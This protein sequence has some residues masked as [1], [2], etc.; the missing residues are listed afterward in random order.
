MS[1]DEVLPIVR[2]IAEA[3][4]FAHEH[5]IVHRDL[6][7]ANIKVRSDGAVKVLDFGLAKAIE[8][9]GAAMPANV[10]QLSTLT[11]PAVTQAGIILGT[12]AYMSPEQARGNRVDKRADIWAFG[13]ILFEMLTGR[14]AHSGDTVAD[15][16]AGIISREPDWS[17]LRADT[18]G[19][20]RRLLERCL[21]KDPYRR[22]RDIGEARVALD[23][24]SDSGTRAVR[25]PA[26]VPSRR[27][28]RLTMLASL[29]A[30]G[31]LAAAAITALQHN[32]TNP[33]AAPASDR[34]P[35]RLVVLPFE[36]L[37]GQSGDQWLA[38]AFS[39]SLTLGLQGVQN[40]V[41]LNRERVQEIDARRSPGARGVAQTLGAHYYVSGSYQRVGDDLKVVARL[42]ETD[43][44]TI[45]HQEAIT[46]RFANVLSIEEQLARRF[47]AALEQ[48]SAAAVQ[49]VKTSS[50]DAYRAVAEA[51][52]LYLN[53]RFAEAIARL[54]SAT[55]QDPSYAEAWALLGKSY[56]QRSAPSYLDRNTRS[57][58][59]DRA[60]QASQ[61]AVE[62]DN[63]LYD[64]QVALAAT[65][66]QLEQVESWR[67]AA[68]KATRLNPG[69]P[70]PT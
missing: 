61:H 10:S 40:I 64:A 46:D 19:A 37:S 8:P 25:F 36:N 41:L 51:N 34:G 2:Q 54:E 17:L 22:L 43:G 69:S 7:P 11:P 29:L 13:A 32:L 63:T 18:P 23:E 55:T 59:I 5:G 60:L 28:R 58:F 70:M 3:L 16:L 48:S 33:P 21:E 49:S 50:V 38:G 26:G 1:V 44:G 47:A 30:G 68:E 45:G 57:E 42:V 12:A 65:Y 9:V 20:L 56:A 24:L 15:I 66:Q 67:I 4:E 53:G 62:L 6:K 39:D 35:S 14:R 52:D 31:I 27:S